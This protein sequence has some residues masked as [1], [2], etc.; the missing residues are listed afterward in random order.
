MG[1]KN[2]SEFHRPLASLTLAGAKKIRDQALLKACELDAAISVVVVDR[3][4]SLLL[5]ETADNA[6]PGAVD[7]SILKAKGAALYGVATHFT[8]EVLKKLPPN[9]AAPALSLP[10][11][12]ALQGGVPVVI[13]G[14]VAGAVGVSG[15]SGEQDVTIATSAAEI[16]S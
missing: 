16:L 11:V 10:E 7:A 14:E 4:G 13:A 12:C 2:V 1:T 15:G 8:A 5:V 6:P 3:L 9:L